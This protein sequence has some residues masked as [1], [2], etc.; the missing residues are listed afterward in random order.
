MPLC[1][2]GR[3]PF[4]NLIIAGISDAGS[5]Y[6]AMQVVNQMLSYDRRDPIAGGPLTASCPESFKMEKK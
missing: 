2:F 3:T 6:N 4:G 1:V 5:T